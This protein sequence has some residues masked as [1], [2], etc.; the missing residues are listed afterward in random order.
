MRSGHWSSVVDEVVMNRNGAAH[1]SQIVHAE[2]T[3]RQ[4]TGEVAMSG[5][6]FA[7]RPLGVNATLM[8]AAVW[9]QQQCH[10]RQHRHPWRSNKCHHI[11][12]GGVLGVATIS[13]RP[14]LVGGKGF[15]V[16]MLTADSPGHST[17][18]SQCRP[19]VP[20]LP[21]PGCRFQGIGAPLTTTTRPAAPRWSP[22]V[23]GPCTRSSR[24]RP[25]ANV[26]GR[27]RQNIWRDLIC[28]VA[29]GH[30]R[31]GAS[32]DRFGPQQRR[33]GRRAWQRVLS[34]SGHGS[35]HRSKGMRR[36]RRH[37]AG[38]DVIADQMVWK[39]AD[40]SMSCYAPAA[41]TIASVRKPANRPRSSP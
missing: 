9:G 40:Q 41:V 39:G 16:Y 30:G 10:S 4:D 33:L 31:H 37:G 12:T 26:R 32:Q 25:L 18:P 19:L 38:G 35:W 22:L 11:R 2:V 3:A 13:L 14:V 6:T 28:R 24:T 34:T 36:P 1:A 23:A 17:C 20:A 8:R 15:T 21:G 27:G 7:V 29:F 5:S